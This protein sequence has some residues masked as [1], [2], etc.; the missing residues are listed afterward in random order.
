MTDEDLEL[1][2]RVF[3]TSFP[4][5]GAKCRDDRR[6]TGLEALHHFSVHNITRLSCYRRLD[7]PAEDFPGV[8]AQGGDAAIE[9]FIS[10]I[11]GLLPMAL[12]GRTSL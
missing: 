10:D 3:R 7:H 2:L 4:R 12:C 11:G 8:M 5:R 9:P 1:A 6:L